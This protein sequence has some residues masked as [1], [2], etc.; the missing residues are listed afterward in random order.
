MMWFNY[1][2]KKI[3]FQVYFPRIFFKFIFKCWHER[4]IAYI[5]INPE[6]IMII[7][8]ISWLWKILI[9]QKY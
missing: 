5:V 6:I 7:L 4:E 1:I 3:Y 2:M 9:A 8:I